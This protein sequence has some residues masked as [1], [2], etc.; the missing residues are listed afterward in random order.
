M[1]ATARTG[2]PQLA[3]AVRAVWQREVL[4]LTGLVA[5]ALAVRLIG[6]TRESLWYDEAY[7]V[8]ISN[9]NIASLKLLWDW[10]IE[11]PLYYLLFYYWL[12]L[13]GQGEFAVRLFGALAGTAA[14]VPMYRLGKE[15]F[16]RR[17]GVIAAL[18]LA[19]SPYHIWYSQEVRMHSWAVLLTLLSLY[20]FWR[21]VRGG[22]WGW[23]LLHTAV[24]G[25]SLHLHYYIGWIVLAENAYYLVYTWRARGG[26]FSRE[27]WRAL[28]WWLLDQGI[29]LLIAI[30]AAAVFLARFV[31]SNDWGWLVESYHAPGLRELADLI[32]IYVL[33][34]AF[35]GPSWLRWGITLG[36][37]AL[38]AWGMWRVYRKRVTEGT[39]WAGLWLAL[40]ALGLPVSLIFIL[41]QFAAV[42]VYRYL[43]L[44]I[45]G[46][47]L[48]VAV[49]IARVPWAGVRLGTL[50][51]LGL[52]C[53]YA[54][55]GMYVGQHK[56][57]WRGVAAYITAHSGP[58]DLIVIMDEE[59]RV[60]FNY[61][62]GP[63][64]ARVE[65]SRFADNATLD[66]ATTDIQA[67][68]Q[69]QRVWL[70]ISH[71]DGS[72]L[73]QRIEGLVGLASVPGPEFVGIRLVVFQRS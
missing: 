56:E 61:Y 35:P 20:A 4:L 62:F 27:G 57:D 43:L 49:G 15:L 14:V 47:L 67:K 41:G 32:G 70:V 22:A 1:M 60:P 48:L 17:V 68:L 7:S 59:C 24:T 40:A 21:V 23:W 44:F 28:R 33:G 3:P 9:M 36:V 18:L 71:A 42:W 19:V 65:V 29:V 63:A 37:L 13:F 54:W 26:L 64:G 12:R 38:A 66:Q 50:A 2:A 46:F 55:G 52:V 25:L 6:L 39:A 53:L 8:W 16:G 69:G 30:P 58:D 34:T 73:E 11:F 72:G 31:S 51:A 5:V 45:P 10:K